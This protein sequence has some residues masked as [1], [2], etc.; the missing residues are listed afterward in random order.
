MCRI[1]KTE[2]EP[3]SFRGYKTKN[4]SPTTEY[5]AE[6]VLKTYVY[7]I[8][9]EIPSSSCK[10]IRHVRRLSKACFPIHLTLSDAVPFAP[11]NS[12]PFAKF[13]HA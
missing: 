5:P 8:C 3:D 9:T 6:C 4:T 2:V 12:M 13:S 1:N 10:F 11:A 7:G